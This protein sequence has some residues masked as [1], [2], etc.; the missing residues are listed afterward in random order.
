[1]TIENRTARGLDIAAGAG[2]WIKITDRETGGRSYGIR[3][4]DGRRLYNVSSNGCTCPDRGARGATCKHMRAVRAFE[5][6]VPAPSPVAVPERPQGRPCTK[7][8]GR[9]RG[10]SIYSQCDDCSAAGGWL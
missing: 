8:G 2:Q 1:M 6:T 4:S 3:S 10:E 9:V 5:A 7:C